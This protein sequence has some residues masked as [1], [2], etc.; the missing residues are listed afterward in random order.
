[1]LVAINSV[2]MVKTIYIAV[3]ISMLLASFGVAGSLF[4]LYIKDFYGLESITP[5]VLSFTLSSSISVIAMFFAGYIYDKYGASLLL[6]IASIS[7]AGWAILIYYMNTFKFWTQ[8]SIIWYAAS[9]VQGFVSPFIMISFN[10]ML[11][12]IFPTKKGLAVSVTQSAQA[13]AMVFW[14]YVFIYLIKFVG[15]FNALTTTG[16]VSSLSILI[17]AIMFR[18]IEIERKKIENNNMI[19]INI[20]LENKEIVQTKKKEKENMLF[21]VFIMILFIAISSIIITNFLAGI[22]EELFT[23]INVDDLIREDLV[24]KVMML[25]GFLQTIT[26]IAWGYVVDKIGPLK[27]I[28]LVY[29]METLFTALSFTSYTINPCVSTFSITLRYMFFSAEPIAHWI[30]IPTFF[31]EKNIGK[32]AGILNSAPMIALVISPLIGGIIRDKTNSYKH[33]LLLSSLLSLLSLLLY[34]ILRNLAMRFRK[35]SIL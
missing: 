33:I 13:L 20:D 23:Y 16:F 6:I 2:S 1:M 27:I 24:P 7:M 21:L 34:T 9:I 22:I 19:H 17:T 25:S 3:F 35:T 12:K 14:P 29:S 11:M 10:P 32:I 30:L 15:F 18:R 4:M 28:P 5:I 31:S 26:A 8:A